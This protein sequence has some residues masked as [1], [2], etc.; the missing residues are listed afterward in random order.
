M[1]GRKL[2]V[3]LDEDRRG[4]RA[5]PRDSARGPREG[6]ARGPRDGGRG[7]VRLG[8]VE[9]VRSVATVRSGAT[10]VRVANAAA[11][12]PVRVPIEALAPT[13]GRAPDRGAAGG[14]G[15]KRPTERRRMG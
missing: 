6:G 12:P 5:A 8:H 10:A 11:D 4:R 3:R 9:I 14:G 2:V 7:D 13:G 15:E 1:R